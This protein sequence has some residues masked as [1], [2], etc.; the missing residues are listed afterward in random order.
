MS[1]NEDV[2]KAYAKVLTAKSKMV[3]PS[4]DQKGK[5]GWADPVESYLHAVQSWVALMDRSKVAR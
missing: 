3:E 1:G 2:L 5:K 4:G